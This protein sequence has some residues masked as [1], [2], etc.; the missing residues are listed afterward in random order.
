M[1]N[2][3]LSTVLPVVIFAIAFGF[4]EASVVVYLWHIIGVSFVPPQINKNQILLSLPG[5]GFLDP[6][7]AVL[8]MKDSAIYNVEMVRE[9]ATIIMLASIAFIAA[10]NS[11]ERFAYFLLAFCVWDIFYYVFLHL[12]IGWPASFFDL[13]IFFLLPVPWVGSVV[14]PI[15]ASI[16][17][18]LISLKILN[19]KGAG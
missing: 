1:L 5:I 10:K 8:I 17:V 14:T 16:V 4:V 3:K 6:K 7:T 15:V 12:T 2:S 13:D 18:I 11:L 9:G 19:R